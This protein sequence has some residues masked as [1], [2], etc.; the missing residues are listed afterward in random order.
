VAHEICAR[1]RFK[2]ESLKLAADTVMAE[3]KALGGTGGVIVTGPSG[4]MAWSF[5]TPACIV[6]AWSSG[7]R[8][9]AFYG[10]DK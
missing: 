3:T 8:L 1:V 10:D 9:V 4:E 2:G 5:N 7:E 6:R